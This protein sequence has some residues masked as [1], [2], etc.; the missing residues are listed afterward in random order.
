MEAQGGLLRQDGHRRTPGGTFFAI[1]RRHCP[2]GDWRRLS[3]NTARRPHVDRRPPVCGV[4][5][6]ELWSAWPADMRKGGGKVKVVLTGRPKETLEPEGYV[7]LQMESTAPE[8]PARLAGAPAQGLVWTV[9]IARPQ[10]QAVTPALA[11][12]ARIS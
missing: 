5:L 3:L 7:M 11:G 9:L 10:W 6:T 8:L 2:P 12:I 4:P 1:A